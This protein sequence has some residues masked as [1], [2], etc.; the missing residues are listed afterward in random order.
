MRE[1]TWIKSQNLSEITNIQKTEN[2]CCEIR[3]EFVCSVTSPQYGTGNTN[4]IVYWI[5]IT[6]LIRPNRLPYTSSLTSQTL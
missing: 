1:S 2:L 4:E 3:H 6:R 5:S